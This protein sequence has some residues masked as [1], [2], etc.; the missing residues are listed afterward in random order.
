VRGELS[1]QRFVEG[2]ELLQSWFP[3]AERLV[4]PGAGHLLMVQNPTAVAAG[5]HGFLARHPIGSWHEPDA[6]LGGNA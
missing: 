6:V 3:S 2:S 4:V 1:A 5:L